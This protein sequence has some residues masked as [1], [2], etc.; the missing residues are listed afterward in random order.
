M[1]LSELCDWSLVDE[2]T[3]SEEL[4]GSGGGGGGGEKESRVILESKVDL[5]FCVRFFSL[6]GV[7]GRI[8]ITASILAYSLGSLLRSPRLTLGGLHY[9]LSSLSLCLQRSFVGYLLLPAPGFFLLSPVAKEANNTSALRGFHLSTTHHDLF[10][11]GGG[12]R[13]LLPRMA[14]TPTNTPRVPTYANTDGGAGADSVGP[15][16]VRRP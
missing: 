13:E 5:C 15:A 6:Q 12:F 14:N 1:L 7:T 4:G 3:L 8:H 16:D 11:L 9:L 2:R 10:F